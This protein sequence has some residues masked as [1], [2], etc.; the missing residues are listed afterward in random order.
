MSEIMTNQ[1]IVEDR[2]PEIEDRGS[3]ADFNYLA[4]CG[5]LLFVGTAGGTLNIAA[6]N[7]ALRVR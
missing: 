1:D 3:G 2:D 4:A 7:R 6:L 5:Y